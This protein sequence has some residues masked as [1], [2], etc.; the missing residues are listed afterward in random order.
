M[1]FIRWHA[2]LGYFLFVLYPQRVLN[3]WKV[4]PSKW[5]FEW[6]TVVHILFSNMAYALS[7]C[8]D[9]FLISLS[10]MF[11]DVEI[12]KG[13][14]KKNQNSILQLLLNKIMVQSKKMSSIDLW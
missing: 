5:S 7:V 1:V 12:S 13:K 9:P 2:F 6:A 3:Y 4:P 8:Y 10:Y 11:R 14:E